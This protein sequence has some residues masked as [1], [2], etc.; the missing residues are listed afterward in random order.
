MTALLEQF[1]LVYQINVST[2]EAGPLLG[3]LVVDGV[4]EA[5][6]VFFVN[7][8]FVHAIVETG[9]TAFFTELDV[10]HVGFRGQDAV[11]VFPRA[12]QF[13]QVF[14]THLLGVFFQHPEVQ[15]PQ[16]SE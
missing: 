3:V 4:Y 9:V 8:V 2:F 16:Q 10:L 11:I 1:G 7:E 15:I 13:V 14:C 6:P 12:E 5:T